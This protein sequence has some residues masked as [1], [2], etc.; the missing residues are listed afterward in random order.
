[1]ENICI[2]SISTCFICL[3][4]PL[5]WVRGLEPSAVTSTGNLII[6]NA[7]IYKLDADAK[8]K[9]SSGCLPFPTAALMLRSLSSASSDCGRCS[10]SFCCDKSPGWHPNRACQQRMIEKKARQLNGRTPDV[11]SQANTITVDLL[12]SEN[13]K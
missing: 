6:A 5:Y 3:H 9:W 11:C 7:H 13:M 8:R 4:Y 2:C 10:W 12:D 1:L